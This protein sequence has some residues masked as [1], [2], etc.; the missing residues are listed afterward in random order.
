MEGKDKVIILPNQLFEENELIDNKTTVYLLEHPVYFQLYNFHKLKLVLHRAT[1]KEYQ[2]YLK[3]EYRCKVKYVEFNKVKQILNKLRNKEVHMYDPVDHIVE[4]NLKKHN[5]DITFYSSP[6]FINKMENIYEYI[7][8]LTKSKK[9]KEDEKVDGI[10]E[11]EIYAKSLKE[12]MKLSKNIDQFSHTSFYGWMRKKHRILIS[13]GKY[14]GGKL[15]F[16]VKNRESFPEIAK[17]FKPN[18]IPST[19]SNKYV[20]EAIKYVEKNFGDNPGDLEESAYYIPTNHNSARL[21]FGKFLRDRLK[22]FG[23]YQ[24]AVHNEIPFGCHSVI[25]AMVN[26]GLL[27]SKYVVEQAERYG[28]KNNVPIQSLEGFIR[29]VLG[30]REYCYLL[31]RL[32]RSEL[33]RGNHFE[34]KRKLDE[35]I[36]YYAEGTTGIQ[37]VDDMIRKAVKYS[38]LHHIERLMYIGN[39]FLIN[40]IH[41]K[42]VH[43]WFISVVSI[44]AYHWVMYPN[45]YGMSQHSTGNI[46]MNRP[47]FSSSSYIDKM[48]NY[49]KRKGEF[50]PISLNNEY[51]DWFEV[52]DAL[53]YNFINENKSEFAKNYAISAQ[54]KH[55]NQKSKSEKDEL[56]KLANSY[57]RKY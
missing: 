45:V 22:C 6:L 43:D 52:W 55:W 15:S 17:D 14:K 7:S 32:K 19:V 48:S 33:E 47:Y 9:N 11:A 29:Q 50:E 30:W 49:N 10:S 8:H 28:N 41:P 54:V 40:K 13:R 39:Y 16:D 35:D 38:Y 27:S 36:W 44:D 21:H 57:M 5:L 12:A 20:K 37:M 4:A 2:S 18:Y 25:S 31:Y 24:D 56:K 26:I 53:Y 51:Y 1:M 42:Q 46:M 34:H 3:K 23:P